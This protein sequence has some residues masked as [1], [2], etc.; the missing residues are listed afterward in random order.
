MSGRSFIKKNFQRDM[1]LSK[2]YF[3]GEK[4][5]ECI[6]VLE[7]TLDKYESDPSHPIEKAYSL[8]IS[9]YKDMRMP[10]DA[11]SMICRF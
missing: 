2:L 8:L 3:K 6:N 7:M 10:K 11:L 1:L 5:D 4:F 9:V